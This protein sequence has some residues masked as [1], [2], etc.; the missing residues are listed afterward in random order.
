MPLH[1]HHCRATAVA[2]PANPGDK[3][4]GLAPLCAAVPWDLGVDLQY[5]PGSGPAQVSQLSHQDLDA[6]V[7]AV[8]EVAATRRK[9]ADLRYQDTGQRQKEPVPVHR[10]ARRRSRA[11]RCRAPSAT[12]P[13][14]G[15]YVAKKWTRPSWSPASEAPYQRPSAR[16]RAAQLTV[17]PVSGAR[18]SGAWP[19]MGVPHLNARL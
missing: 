16:R 11:R 1:R 4:P 10:P 3:A 7:R 8:P 2:Q 19:C 13:A 9:G 14:P 6:Y 17:I 15:T 12:C 5:V 18:H